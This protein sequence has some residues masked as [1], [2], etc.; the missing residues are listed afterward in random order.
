[1][2]LSINTLNTIFDFFFHNMNFFNYLP[3]Y[4]NFSEE[5]YSNSTDGEEEYEE[6][7]EE[8]EYNISNR[9]ID[10]IDLI[11]NTSLEMRKISLTPKTPSDVKNESYFG[12]TIKKI[13]KT[14][15]SEKKKTISET[16]H[17]IDMSRSNHETYIASKEKKK[18]DIFNE[19][20]MK[21]KK[22]TSSKQLKGKFRN[23][24]YIELEILDK[25]EQMDR[26]DLFQLKLHE[27][28]FNIENALLAEK[29]MVSTQKL[30]S[31]VN[32]QK[33]LENIN[34]SMEDTLEFKIDIEEIM[35][36]IKGSSISEM[37]DE[38]ELEK[39]L[40][41]FLSTNGQTYDL[42]KVENK[43]PVYNNNNNNNNNPNG[44]FI[45]QHKPVFIEQKKTKKIP[46]KVNNNN[47]TEIIQEE[48]EESIFSQQLIKKMPEL[49]ENLENNLIEEEAEES[50]NNDDKNNN[51]DNNNNNNSE[52]LKEVVILN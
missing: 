50:K 1:M 25:I 27:T 26:L 29:T 36:S 3:S 11:N 15:H 35:E 40:E 39:E 52:L 12:K 10:R 34:Q 37:E 14:P 47:N 51:D 30:T 2:H 5:S 13:I 32:T 24:K 17:Y 21:K 42:T 48:E 7:E 49:P 20:I 16:I 46:M 43:Q 19:I 38:D 23:L 41:L 6:E 44:N 22:G 9:N 28:F 8:E 45:Y 31:N 18:Q 4:F 33:L